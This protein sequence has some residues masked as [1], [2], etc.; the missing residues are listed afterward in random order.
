MDGR[1]LATDHLH[2]QLKERREQQGARVLPCGEGVEP[3]VQLLRIETA[4]QH[5]PGHGGDGEPFG[6]ATQD[7]VEQSSHEETSD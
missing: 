7:W 3:G 1:V 6:K 2:H 4:L 5:R